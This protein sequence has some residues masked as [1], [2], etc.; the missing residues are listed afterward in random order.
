MIKIYYASAHSRS[1]DFQ[2]IGA[3]YNEAIGTLHKGLKAHAKA[4]N[5]EPK[6]FEQWADIRVQEINSGECLRDHEPIKQI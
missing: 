1:F 2:A 3:T 4:Y 5:L 6:W